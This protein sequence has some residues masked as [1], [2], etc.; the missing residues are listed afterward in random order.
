MSPRKKKIPT[1]EFAIDAGKWV[2]GKEKYIGQL[3]QF[4]DEQ[5]TGAKS[6]KDGNLIT[7]S[8][9]T[10]ISKK[11]LKLRIN[12]FLYQAGLKTDYRLI[13]LAKKDVSGFRIFTR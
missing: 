9:P 8:L 3:M 13:A 2:P 5:I 10:T 6:T 12:K 4:L 1:H 7:V 11:M